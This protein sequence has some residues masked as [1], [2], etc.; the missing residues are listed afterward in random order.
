[1]NS[2]GSFPRHIAIIMDGNGRWATQRHLPRTVGHHE[3]IQRVREIVKAC[4]E[5]KIEVL[6]LFVFSTENW[7]RPSVEVKTLMRFLSVYLGREVSSLHK[8]NIR[9]KFIGRKDHLPKYVVEKIERI[10]QKTRDNTGL[11]LMLAVNYG[12]RQE[13]VDA[14]KNIARE[15]S[16]GLIDAD[17]INEETVSSYL[18]TQ[19]L[20]DPDLLIRTSGEQRISNFLLWQL[21][22]AELYFPKKFWP[23]FKKADLLEALEVYANRGRRFGGIENRGVK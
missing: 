1:M 18:Y 22:Y 5:L 10:E 11:T 21:S 4:T 14:V 3:G 8:R 13:I 20:A 15:C 23:D 17:S 7:S 9:V 6:T 2:G 19:G 16:K 12:S